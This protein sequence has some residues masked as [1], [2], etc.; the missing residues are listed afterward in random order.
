[1]TPFRSVHDLQ[2]I[3][4]FVA[5]AREGSLTRASR[6]LH[7]T[8]SAISV[9]LKLLQDRLGMDLFVRTSRGLRLTPQG[10][11][12]MP[13]AEHV[14]QTIGELEAAAGNMV[15]V[16][17][18]TVSIGTILSPSFIRLGAILQ[19]M[20]HRHP[21]I[22]TRL[23]HSMTGLIL[24]QIRAGALDAGF[25]L[26]LPGD[27]AED[28]LC[29]ARLLD[30][31]YKVI[32]PSGWKDRIDGRGW[33]GLMLLPWI[34]APPGSAHHRMLA[35]ICDN[36]GSRPH[37][38]VEVDFETSMVELVRAGV[39]LSLAR[40]VLAYDEAKTHGIVISR[41]VE[42]EVPLSFIS[43]ARRRSEPLIE[44]TF[45][46]VQTAFE[47]SLAAADAEVA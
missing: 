26:G 39:G 11:K 18:G 24:D 22:R 46:A 9:Q 32:A 45:L 30:I 33:R 4:A 47:P 37:T 40:D 1:M 20:T 5:V 29:S 6:F 2:H 36:I 12:L 3:R 17:V 10:I 16:P 41:E 35:H 15:S 7:L 19:H 44:A 27:I 8:Q 21:E 38:V 13:Y 34:G 31:T 23:C 43:L 28:E 14:L 25:Y 42:I